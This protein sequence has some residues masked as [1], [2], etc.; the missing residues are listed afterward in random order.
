MFGPTGTGGGTFTAAAPPINGS[1]H[2][3]APSLL[4][5]VAYAA[6]NQAGQGQATTTGMTVTATVRFGSATIGTGTATVAQGT[7]PTP[8]QITV[9]VDQ[10][11]TT[12]APGGSKITVEVVL[13]AAPPAG[14]AGVNDIVIL[15]GSTSFLDTFPITAGA[16]GDADTDGD[17][18]PD[19]EDL[20]KDG[21]TV[22][23]T[24]EAAVVCQVNDTT[25]DFA[26][27]RNLAPG[28]NDGDGDGATDEEECQAGS[29]PKSALSTPPQPAAFPWALL[30]FLLLLIALI[31]AVVFFFLTFGKAVK[32]E[33]LSASQLIIPAG[34]QAK[35]QVQ[36]TNVRKKG[37]AINYQ[38]AALGTPEGWDAKLSVDHVVLDPQGGAK[39]T[40]TLWLTVESP[41]QTDPESAVV[42]VRAVA[43][44]AKGKK[45]TLKLPGKAKTITSVNV[46]AD[47][48]VPVKKGAA[49]K[50]K[51][52][53]EKAAE[54]TGGDVHKIIDIEG[55]GPESE[56]KL[57]A[58]GI[59]DTAQLQAA[60][61]KKLA[62]KTGIPEATIVSWQQMSDLIRVK[63]IG[64]QFAELLVRAGVTSTVQLAGSSAEDV[65][66]K[67]QGYLDS[68]EQKPTVGKFNEKI[69]NKWIDDAKRLTGVTETPAAAAPAAEAAGKA[70]PAA[71]AAAP[72]AG[73]KPQLQVGN[74]QH[75]PGSF[76]QGDE[77]KSTVTVTN[78]GGAAHT[79]K[80][81][82]YVNDQLADAQT[83]SVKP[84]KEK[85]VKFKWTAQESNRLNIR[86]EI[87]PG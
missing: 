29:D 32:V 86:G 17:G 23:N 54:S 60:D 15:C 44:N 42:A 53:K 36:V 66:K 4:V 69:V 14:P 61:A 67:M 73:E 34:Q 13:T 25:Y 62:K 33:I 83:V 38:L 80:L 37:N 47:A 7:N 82:L 76:H 55:I 31:V 52:E 12:V 16:V 49:V 24:A 59:T 30:I 41:Q 39:P 77:V 2:T 20:D 79:L 28:D 51:T 21:D 78:K 45:D 26:S 71:A 35:Y 27:D 46:P 58:E 81:S 22:P 50:V 72:P 87:V 75:N 1:Y 48:K 57:N 43:L 19:S 65:V 9:N 70:A 84:G 18:V 68:V 10:S 63:G 11:N 64:K 40:E 3:T 85:D 56:K 8:S 74:L 5:Q 6:G